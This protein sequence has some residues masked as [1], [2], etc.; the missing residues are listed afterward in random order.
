MSHSARNVWHIHHNNSSTSTVRFE[1]GKWNE[2][3]L[4]LSTLQHDYSHT[5]FQKPLKFMLNTG[6]YSSE[7]IYRNVDFRSSTN[8]DTQTWVHKN[9][10]YSEPVLEKDSYSD[11]Y[12]MPQA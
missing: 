4:K 5:F 8:G 2:T 1:E 9:Y 10:T 12:V 6:L 7:K 11:C 3:G